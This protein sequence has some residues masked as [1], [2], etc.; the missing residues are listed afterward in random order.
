M[1]RSGKNKGSQWEKYIG[2][3]VN[4]FGHTPWAPDPKTWHGMDSVPSFTSQWIR[5][6]QQNQP[7]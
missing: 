4:A 6:Q 3:K 5:H 1:F 2:S 7:Q